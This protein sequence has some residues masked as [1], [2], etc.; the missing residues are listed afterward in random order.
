MP[1]KK[2]EKERKLYNGRHLPKFQRVNG[3]MLTPTAIP[4]PMENIV[5]KVGAPPRSCNWVLVERLAMLHCTPAEICAVVQCDSGT[6]LRHPKFSRIYKHGWVRGMMSL[7]RAQFKKAVTEGDTR[8]MI[9]LG[10]QMLGQRDYWLGDPV[11]EPPPVDTEFMQ[12][13]LDFR[14][15]SVDQ[16]ETL[17]DLI[18]LAGGGSIA[19]E[20]P[21]SKETIDADAE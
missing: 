12:G 3:K 14:K 18:V 15:L 17:R 13:E 8:M 10:K 9:F 4:V 7:R 5:G 11:L 21:A 6:L 20:L 2:T 19:P 1:P 16:M